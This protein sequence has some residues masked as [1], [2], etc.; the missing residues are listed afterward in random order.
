MGVNFASSEASV[1]ASSSRSLS[2][3]A[4][5]IPV[6]SEDGTGRRMELVLLLFLLL[7]LVPGVG[8]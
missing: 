1:A 5:H 2:R 4:R 3:M 7:T 6:S 8:V